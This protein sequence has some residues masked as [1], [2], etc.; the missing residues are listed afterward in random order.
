MSLADRE[1]LTAA[2][3]ALDALP[4]ILQEQAAEDA[5]TANSCSSKDPHEVRP[6]AA[7]CWFLSWFLGGQLAARLTSLQAANVLRKRQKIKVSGR[8]PAP[9]LTFGGLAHQ[10]ALPQRL[11]RNLQQAGWHQ[12]SAVQQQA[13][14]ALLAG[15]ELLV[16]APTGSGKTLAF[17]LPIVA[18]LCQE[19][20]AAGDATEAQ[21]GP[22]TLLVAP[23]RELAAQTARVLLQLVRGLKLRT[24]LLSSAAAAG[25]DFSKV[26]IVITAPLRAAKLIRKQ[27]LLLG[28]VRFLVLDEA[29]RL[30][31]MGFLQ[32]VDELVAA[33]AHPAVVR[34][35]YSATLPESV[36]D[37]A[38]SVLKDPLRI[39]VGERNAAAST[40]AQ[41]LVFVGREQ[42]KLLALRQLLAQGVS[43]P[44]LVFVGSKERAIELHQQLLVE[45]VSV[46]VIHGNQPAAARE[47][48]VQQVRRGR[49]GLLIA[50]D[51][52]ARGVDWLAVSTVVNYDFPASTVD[53]IHRIGRTGRAGR[54]GT[55]I[56]FYTE[57]DS[58]RLR[59][60]ANVMKAAGC[61]VPSWMLHLRKEHRRKHRKD[62][63]ALEENDDNS[64]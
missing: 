21:T 55:A 62:E 6:T 58:W 48:A 33:C 7:A 42:G 46:E 41:R 10:Y 61:E 4:Q 52:V 8:A 60:I 25:T 38:R 56:T 57:S 49:L 22:R 63:V 43:P 16:V 32:Q 45:G 44:V 29:D 18:K 17:L 14:P 35:L 26:D 31:Q 13:I 37:L 40:I 12:P 5:T 23:T 36:E 3:D 15:R 24:S 50:T 2:E 30:F 27:H 53:Y 64:S 54:S 34:A 59:S 19:R 9:M 20:E 11:M 39:V 28:D 1:G 51:L 47:A